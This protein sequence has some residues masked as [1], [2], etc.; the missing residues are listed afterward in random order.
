MTTILTRSDIRSLYLQGE[1]AVAA[2]IEQFQARLVSLEE[3]VAKHSGNS[4]KP[5]S[6]DG[7]KK[8]PLQPMTVSLRKKTG[9]KVGGQPGHAGTTLEQAAEPDQVVA[10][11]P[12]FCPDCQ[13]SLVEAAL[14]PESPARRQVFEMPVPQVVV[15]EHRA[16]SVTCPGCGKCCRAAFP[17][18][19]TQPVQYGPNLLGFA[20]YLQGVHLLPFERCA[21]VVREVTGAPFSPGSLARALES[22]HGVLAPFEAGVREALAHAPVLHVDETGT[23]VAGKLQRH[24]KL[25]SY[26][27]H[28][29]C[30]P[31]LT[32]LF[33]HERRGAVAV[34]DLLRYTGILVSDF[35]SSYVKLSCKHAYCGAHILRELRFQADVK[36]QGWANGLIDLLEGAVS[37]C[38]QARESGTEGK[39]LADRGRLE[40]A[41]DR[42]VAEGLRENPPPLVGKATPAVNLLE[43]LEA[44]KPSCLRF[45]SDLSVPFT[46]N[47]AERDLRMLKVKGKISGGFRTTEGAD[48]YCRLRSYLATC[49]KQGMALL[50]C[51]QSLFNGHLVTPALIA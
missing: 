47:Q 36:Q 24:S 46:N 8:K 3:Q 7:Y 5:P 22:A 50:D 20:T 27:F 43:R 44:Y 30:T 16:V 51:C 13:A 45:L 23:R 40:A 12:D 38:H 41:Y 2:L 35:L 33:R 19:V 6:S 28:T 26:W 1:E 49:R 4:S 18:G 42:L 21:Q 11:R 29:R 9:K 25:C 48:Q 32:F 15:T 14:A 37:A 34:E 10:H 31:L 17:A 39:G